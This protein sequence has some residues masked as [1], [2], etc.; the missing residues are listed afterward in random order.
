MKRLIIIVAVIIVALLLVIFFR[1]SGTPPDLSDSGLPPDQILPADAPPRTF[2]AGDT[3]AIGTDKG[4]V[5]VKNFYR[6]LVDTEEGF[7]IIRDEPAYMIYYEVTSGAFFIDLSV[8]FSDRARAEIEKSFVALLGVSGEDVC[9]LD[10]TVTSS[11]SPGE[12]RPLSFCPGK[13]K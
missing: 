7:I 10:V 12:T 11:Q 13:V 4:T 8:P 1:K 9:K 5:T 2:P 6:N 3:I